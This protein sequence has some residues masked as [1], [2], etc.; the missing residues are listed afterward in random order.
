MSKLLQNLYEVTRRADY[1]TLITSAAN[2]DKLRQ[3]AFPSTE[4][5]NTL[6]TFAGI[7]VKEDQFLPDNLAVFTNRKNQIVG[8]AKFED[9]KIT[10]TEI[11]PDELYKTMF[12]EGLILAQR[13]VFPAHHTQAA[14]ATLHKELRRVKI[15]RDRLA[16]RLQ[17]SPDHKYDKIDCL[18]ADIALRDKDRAEMLACIKELRETVERSLGCGYSIHDRDK[19]LANSKKWGEVNVEVKE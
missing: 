15:E 4:T 6:E 13:H 19:A 8:I 7:A 2:A 1:S 14:N 3:S 16:A 12:I 18:E 9:D 17:I 5:K 11:D 10:F